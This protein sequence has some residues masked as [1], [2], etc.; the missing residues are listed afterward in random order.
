MLGPSKLPLMIGDLSQNLLG[1]D[2]RGEALL[3]GDSRLA[4]GDN[5]FDEVVL[6]LDKSV[7]GGRLSLA[8]AK[9]PQTRPFADAAAGRP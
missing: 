9:A 4:P 7:L 5:A 2:D 3:A 6:L 1:D 8:P